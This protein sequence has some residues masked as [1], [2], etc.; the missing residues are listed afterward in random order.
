MAHPALEESVALLRRANAA[1]GRLRH[2]LAEERRARERMASWT[3]G[4]RRL[5]GR[6]VEH[7]HDT[8]ARR[9]AE[10]AEARGELATLEGA[11]AALERSVARPLRLNPE[12][13]GPGLALLAL[14]ALRR[15]DLEG[16]GD[17][18]DFPGFVARVEVPYRGL[19]EKVAA[20]AGAMERLR[21]RFR[22][23]DGTTL[24]FAALTLASLD[25]GRGFPEEEFASL[26]ETIRRTS[27][28]FSR[29]RTSRRF[30][31]ASCLLRFGGDPRRRF[32]EVLEA[33]RALLEAGLRTSYHT[34]T[35]AAILTVTATTPEEVRR[36]AARVAA[37]VAEMKRAH[38]WVT[39]PDDYPAA[40][41]LSG[42]PG[43]LAAVLERVEAIHAGLKRAG[44]RG[45]QQLQLCSHILALHP[46]GPERAAER[47]LE[48]VKGFAARGL[49]RSKECWD[50]A[51]LLSLLPGHTEALLDLFE[52]IYRQLRGLRALRWNR[53]VA[54]PAAAALLRAALFDDRGYLEEIF[55]ADTH[56]Y[57]EILLAQA[58]AA[59]AACA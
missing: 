30:L 47:F 23:S 9:R 49:S 35:A 21:R 24:R 2:A 53:K 25:R 4:V 5:F 17:A 41:T 27:R 20:F 10:A 50:E 39:G 36:R 57:A 8:V 37:L 29:M 48:L 22:W 18:R 28:V 34:T 12:E 33:Q 54:F 13:G 26:S 16:P 15:Y 51:A 43:E 1:A 46:E 38:W 6:K 58:E 52:T 45:A 3:Y 44:L 59:A 7:D 19:A 11:L 14:R 32:E 40:A 31:L 55:L 56:R 42:L